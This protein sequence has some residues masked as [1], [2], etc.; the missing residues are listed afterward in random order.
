MKYKLTK[1]ELEALPEDQQGLY[2][3]NDTG[4][5]TL[6]IDGLPDFAK[7]Q[8]D[9]DRATE[10]HRISEDH[11]DKAEKAAK[12][13]QD[14]LAKGGDKEEVQKILDEAKRTQETIRQEASTKI[15]ELET[16][17]DQGMIEGVAT[18]LAGAFTV[19]DLIVP[20]L[21][22]R[23]TVVSADGKQA[24]RV[25][26]PEGNESILTPQDLQKEFIDNPSYAGIIAAKA[27]S[28]SG[29]TPGSSSGATRQK[30]S[31]MTATEQVMFQKQDPEG[32]NAAAK[33]EGQEPI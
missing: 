2:H 25:L 10:K 5:A 11:R 9:L 32:Y 4:E 33:L 30:L 12:S 31:D 1:A 3:L 6:K 27:G 29:A 28:G 19:P 23:L 21:A 20:H 7:M 17:R 14:Q 16:Q 13:L 24:V 22:K 8:A 26:S 15:A 18:K